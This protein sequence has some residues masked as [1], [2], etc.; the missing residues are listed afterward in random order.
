LI[1]VK[2]IK[3]IPIMASDWQPM[4]WL[5]YSRTL[6]GRMKEVQTTMPP[7]KVKIPFPAEG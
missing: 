5:M 3:E 4:W 6:I 1:S 2:A 7:R